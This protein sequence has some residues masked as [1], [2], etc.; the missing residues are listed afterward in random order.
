MNLWVGVWGSFMCVS[1]I[2]RWGEG[3]KRHL[4][5]DIYGTLKIIINLKLSN[6]DTTGL[7]ILP[8]VLQYGTPVFN[9][10]KKDPE[11]ELSE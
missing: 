11:W 3:V 7:R 9:A 1:H 5:H 4:P 8:T 6:V 2:A 10:H